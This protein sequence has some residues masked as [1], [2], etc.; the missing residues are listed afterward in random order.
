MGPQLIIAYL[1][2]FRT[3]VSTGEDSFGLRGGAGGGTTC[4]EAFLALCDEGPALLLLL[5][6]FAAFLSC[7][8]A[9]LFA[10]GVM[11]VLELLL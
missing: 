4:G 2:V 1:G 11:E 7:L 3:L 9:P 10:L 8:T 6:L 5:L